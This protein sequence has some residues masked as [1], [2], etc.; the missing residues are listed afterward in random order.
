MAK[1]LGSHEWSPSVSSTEEYML[2][3][4]GLYKRKVT[5]LRLPVDTR[6]L[7]SQAV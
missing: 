6:L 7:Y 3:M 4:K 5:V 2:S 1:G